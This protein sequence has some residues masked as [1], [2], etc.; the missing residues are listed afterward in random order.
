MNSRIV[1]EIITRIETKE[2]QNFYK[3]IRS[4]SSPTEDHYFRKLLKQLIEKYHGRVK[5][6]L[7]QIIVV[8]FI[9]LKKNE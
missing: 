1:N 8:E 4:D 9:N 7:D 2:Q 6:Y 5:I 3:L